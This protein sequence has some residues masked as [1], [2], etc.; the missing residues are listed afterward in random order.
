[1]DYTLIWGFKFFNIHPLLTSIGDVGTRTDDMGA[2]TGI[3]SVTSH[4]KDPVNYEFDIDI[5]L[6][7]YY[8]PFSA[9]PLGVSY[10]LIVNYQISSHTCSK[11]GWNRSRSFWIMVEN[12]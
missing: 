11:F 8:V 6:Y 4:L 3:P 10:P 5:D 12:A 7:Y 1:M 2:F 9:C